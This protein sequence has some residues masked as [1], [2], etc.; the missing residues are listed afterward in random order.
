VCCILASWRDSDAAAGETFMLHLVC[1]GFPVTT[2][3]IAELHPVKERDRRYLIVE[4]L[5]PDE[6]NPEIFF[7]LISVL[8]LNPKQ[9]K[10]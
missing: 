8:Y 3:N 1:V 4:S 6:R 5:A 2:C 7:L 9:L 10:P